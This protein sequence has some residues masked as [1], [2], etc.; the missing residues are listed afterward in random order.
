MK[1]YCRRN[2]NA[3]V[4]VAIYV[5]VLVP[6]WSTHNVNHG[7]HWLAGVVIG[8]SAVLASALLVWACRRRPRSL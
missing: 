3:G 8:V 6:I 2:N 5:A 4:W 7:R 1:W